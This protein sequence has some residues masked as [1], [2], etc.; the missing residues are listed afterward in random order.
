MAGNGEIDQQLMALLFAN[1]DMAAQAPMCPRRE[2]ADRVF[3]AGRCQQ[4]ECGCPVIGADATSKIRTNI[5]SYASAL[6]I[7][8]TAL[9]YIIKEARDGECKLVPVT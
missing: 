4:G 5:I 9:I 3:H 2:P 6:S 1:I 7:A 8:I